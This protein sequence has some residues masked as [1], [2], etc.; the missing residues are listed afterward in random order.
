MKIGEP[1]GKCRRGCEAGAM[2]VRTPELIHWGK[3]VCPKCGAWIDWVRKPEGLRT[4]AQKAAR[5]DRT[6]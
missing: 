1:P 4:D 2:F 5:Y 6:R 3:L